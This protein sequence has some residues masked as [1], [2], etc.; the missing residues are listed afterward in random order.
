MACFS[1]FTAFIY[2]LIYLSQKIKHPFLKGAVTWVL[3]FIYVLIISAGIKLL[4][5]DIYRIPSNSM[6]NTLL[7]NDVVVV[8]KLIWGPKLPNDIFEISWVNLLFQKKSK[9]VVQ[10][11]NAYKR[12]KGLSPIKQGDVL[13]YQVDPSLFVIK[14]CVAV[15][16]DTLQLINGEI[17]TG[18]TKYVAPRTV[19]NRYLIVVSNISQYFKITDSLQP[20]EK[21]VTLNSHLRTIEG[22]FTNNEIK[23]LEKTHS[24][25]ANRYIETYDKNF[26]LF[27]MPE[28]S[29]W[30]LDN[31][32]SIIIP[33]KGLTIRFNPRNYCIY[34]ASIN[35]FENVKLTTDGMNFYINNRVATSYTFKQN[36]YFVM[37]D[38]RKQSADSRYGGFLAEQNIIGKAQF[39]L[40]ST[41]EGNFLWNRFIKIIK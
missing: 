31:I 41:H 26:P 10:H 29:K 35:E 34:K 6:E 38:N 16:G 37:G 14:R 28:N 13:V 18:K 12:L 15:A 21:S 19:K 20:L 11:P 32:D 2:S 23:R 3:K 7:P 33:K 22:D 1:L 5:I 39:I 36:Y 25:K 4:A 9:D 8:N 40:L 24:L 17:Y 27:A 30:T